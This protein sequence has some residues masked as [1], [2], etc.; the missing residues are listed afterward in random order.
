MGGSIDTENR[1]LT[2]HATAGVTEWGTPLRGSRAIRTPG[3]PG[4]RTSG[5]LVSA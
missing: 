1:R 3:R 2:R 5:F 4:S